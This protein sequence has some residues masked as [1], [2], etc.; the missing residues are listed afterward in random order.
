[1]DDIIRFKEKH[2][3]N[4]SPPDWI[5]KA[6]SNLQ[7]FQIF[8]SKRKKSFQDMKQG[9]FYEFSNYLIENNKNNS[10]AY[11]SII[12]FGHFT[13]NKNLV[14]WGREVFD[15]KEVMENLSKRLTEEYSKEFR[16]EIFQNLDVPPLGIDPK[17]KPDYT[18]KLITRLVKKIGEEEAEKFLAKGLRDSYYEW[19]K[20]DRELFLK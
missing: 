18:K 9:D 8:L 15:G 16:D 6:I 12:G 2:I 5:E 10:V 14:I 3:E 17:I 19:R 1:M 4:D 7:E 20:P 11:E 13:N